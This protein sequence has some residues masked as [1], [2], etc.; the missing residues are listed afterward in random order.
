MNELPNYFDNSGLDS[1]YFCLDKT[2]F[3]FKDIQLVNNPVLIDSLILQNSENESTYEDRN[4][5][6]LDNFRAEQDYFFINFDVYVD[7][8]GQYALLILKDNGIGISEKHQKSVFNKFYRIES[9]TVHNT[10]GLGLGL[11]YV[12]SIIEAHNGEIWLESEPGK[13][14]VFHIKFKLN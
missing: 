8:T 6:L 2:S 9:S 11:F 14:S 10:K 13:G 7:F 5:I 3:Y 1:L 12:K 4:G